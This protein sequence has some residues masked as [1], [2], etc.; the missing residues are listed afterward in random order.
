MS[1]QEKFDLSNLMT[2]KVNF[3]NKG[4]YSNVQFFATLLS[5]FYAVLFVN[6]W[7]KVTSGEN[8]KLCIIVLLL[9]WKIK[10]IYLILVFTTR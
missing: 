7:K 6:N 9:C 4:Q 8:D 3:L 2:R 10:N 1:T 5:D